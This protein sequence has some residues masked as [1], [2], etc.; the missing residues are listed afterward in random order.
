MCGCAR[1]FQEACGEGWNVEL[2]FAGKSLNRK[3]ERDTPGREP[4][5]QSGRRRWGAPGVG[6]EDEAQRGGP[7]QE[8]RGGATADGETRPAP[9]KGLLCNSGPLPRYVPLRSTP[10]LLSVC[11]SLP[12]RLSVCL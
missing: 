10:H 8:P 12:P 6:A 5:L 2:R 7:V 9:G 11:V 1:E 3:G 4:C